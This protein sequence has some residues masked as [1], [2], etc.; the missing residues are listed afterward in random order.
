MVPAPV[1]GEYLVGF[2]GHDR[3][4]QQELITRLFFVPALDVHAAA[5]QA[6]LEGN[7]DLIKQLKSQ[8]GVNRQQLR[9]DAQILAVAIA[10]NAEKMI[11][12]DPHMPDLA[13]GRIRV[14]EL[15]ELH[16]QMDMDFSGG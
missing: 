1:V 6:E 11:S 8:H 4:R 15:P 16:E 9:V 2:G 3:P 14:E 13:Q 10:N 12:Y 7:G 5:V